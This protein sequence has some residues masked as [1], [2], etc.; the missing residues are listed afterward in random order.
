MLMCG[1]QAYIQAFIH[2][3]CKNIH[4]Y[5]MK[6]NLK[7]PIIETHFVF[8]KSARVGGGVFEKLALCHTGT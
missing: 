6:I 2:I 1:T 3:K 4:T 7:T 5:K 8:I